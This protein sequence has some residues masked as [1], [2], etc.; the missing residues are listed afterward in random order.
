MRK[1][2]FTVLFVVTVAMAAPRFGGRVGYS[3]T[4][5]PFTGL[6]ADGAIFGGQLTIPMMSILSFE[7]SGTYTSTESDISMDSYLGN[8]LSDEYGFEYS[9]DIDELRN[10]MEN[11]LGWVL[12][13]EADMLEDYTATYH[14]L[15]LAGILRTDIPLGTSA[16]SPYVGGGAGAH[17]VV[18]DADAML[19]LIQQQG[20]G[21][22]A[23]DPYDHIFPSAEG[24]IG[25]TFQPPGA[26]VSMFGEVRLSKPFGDD[27]GDAIY[28]YFGG[29][30]IG[31]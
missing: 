27:A 7:A 17:F 20:T 30:N 31:F 21:E 24:V 18:S 11:D 19:A 6:S 16:F 5:D 3:T 9:G 25:L 4:E 2:L 28:T 14:N 1:L 10:Y 26:P 15:G 12:P 8:Y 22:A 29:A 23:I 13:A